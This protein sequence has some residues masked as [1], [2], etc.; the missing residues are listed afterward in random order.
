MVGILEV[1]SVSPFEDPDSQCV[2]T[3][4]D[5]VGYIK[6]TRQAAV[7]RIT[8][9]LAVDPHLMSGI[10]TSEMKNDPSTLPLLGNRECTHI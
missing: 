10:Y 9:L 1:T 8:D 7:L 2:L 5:Q 4:L 3:L 6:L